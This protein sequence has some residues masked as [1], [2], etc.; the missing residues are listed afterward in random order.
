V[1]SYLVGA[2]ERHLVVLGN[3]KMRR[4]HD[5]DKYSKNRQGLSH[6]VV[7]HLGWSPNDEY[8]VD[9]RRQNTQRHRHEIDRSFSHQKRLD[10]F[11]LTLAYAEKDPDDDGNAQR[12]GKNHVIGPCE[13]ET[14]LRRCR[15]FS[16]SYRAQYGHRS[17]VKLPVKIR[18]TLDSR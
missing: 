17:R 6:S 18:V 1:A 14:S 3:E 2:R 4:Y 5:A 12:D 9:S 7:V 13:E 10:R 8:S 16:E 11:I 15:C